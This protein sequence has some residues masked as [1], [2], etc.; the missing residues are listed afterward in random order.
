MSNLCLIDVNLNE[1]NSKI[2]SPCLK[3]KG[4]RGKLSMK[5]CAKITCACAGI[6]KRVEQVNE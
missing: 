4:H 1:Q 6:R 3:N 5:N 2:F